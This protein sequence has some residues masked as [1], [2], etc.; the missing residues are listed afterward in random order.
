MGKTKKEMVE[1]L[2][3][4]LPALPKDK[5]NHLL[6]IADLESLKQCV[7]LGIDTFDSS[8]PTKAARHGMLLTKQG[9]LKI[10]RG[11]FADQFEP[12]DI[13]N[14]GGI[15]ALGRKENIALL[16]SVGSGFAMPVVAKVASN[17]GLPTFIRYQTADLAQNKCILRNFL[18]A[19]NISPVRASSRLASRTR[20]PRCCFRRRT[21]PTSKPASAASQSASSSRAT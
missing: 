12:I 4:T 3:T 20:S 8:Y 18:A 13:T 1:M 5:P 6:G 7:P 9:S 19:R 16:Y 14:F 15:E 11:V 2:S 21:S 17:L 10:T